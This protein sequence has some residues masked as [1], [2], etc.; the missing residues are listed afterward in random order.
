MI[1]DLHKMTQKPL[2]NLS[3]KGRGKGNGNSEGILLIDQPLKQTIN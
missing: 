2:S 3:P 1:L